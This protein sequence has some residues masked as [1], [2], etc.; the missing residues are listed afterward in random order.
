MYLAFVATGHVPS[1]FSAALYRGGA[2]V[3][4]RV[5]W[6]EGLKAFGQEKTAIDG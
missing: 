2:E 6:A 4:I 3:F 1:L 5:C